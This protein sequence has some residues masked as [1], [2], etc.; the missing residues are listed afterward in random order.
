MKALQVDQTENGYLTQTDGLDKPIY[1]QKS[2]PWKVGDDLDPNN[3]VLSETGKSYRRKW[4]QPT[5]GVPA[6]SPKP[7]VAKP[8]TAPPAQSAAAHNK[9]EDIFL[10][11]AFKGATELAIARN[12]PSDKEVLMST[13]ILYAGLLKLRGSVEVVKK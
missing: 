10:S 9:D 7:E 13:Q 2:P 4:K 8:V 12:L 11:V 5:V 1:T 3:F 6:V